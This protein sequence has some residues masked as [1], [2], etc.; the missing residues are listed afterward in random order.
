MQNELKIKFSDTGSLYILNPVMADE[1]IERLSYIEASIALDMMRRNAE[2]AGELLDVCD[3]EIE[4]HR[5]IIENLKG[6]SNP[7]YA[8]WIIELERNIGRL[9]HHA[10][11]VRNTLFQCGLL[12][13]NFSPL[14]DENTTLNQR[15]N[16]LKVDVADRFELTESDGLINIVFAYGLENSAARRGKIFNTGVMSR[17]LHLVFHD[18]L[19]STGQGHMLE[20]FPVEK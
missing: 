20:M 10:D 18:F 7:F 4:S 17:A 16:L 15:C 14:F 1:R 11:Q 6:C 2:N 9:R 12:L 8:T 19:L 3:R 5:V 13:A